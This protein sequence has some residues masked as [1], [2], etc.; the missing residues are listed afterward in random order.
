LLSGVSYLPARRVG[1][2]TIEDSAGCKISL[3]PEARKV[4]HDL[5]EK[6][7]HVSLDSINRRQ[8]AEEVLRTLKL[9]EIIEHPRINFNDKGPNILEI[10]KDF[11]E[12]DNLEISPDEVMFIDDVEQFCLDAKRVLRGKGT[13]PQMGRD[14]SHLSE[15]LQMI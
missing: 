6:R 9:D 15:L 13:V 11:R 1:I 3:N 5:K 7:I 2:D 8:E 10:L 14:I 12:K 4:L